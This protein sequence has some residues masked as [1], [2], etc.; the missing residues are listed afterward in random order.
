VEII[1]MARTDEEK[2][3]FLEDLSAKLKNSNERF[4]KIYEM[5]LAK[6]EEEK[7]L[8][9]NKKKNDVKNKTK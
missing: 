8:A 1:I 3:K 2:I 4:K 7:M 6:Y 5:A 9:E